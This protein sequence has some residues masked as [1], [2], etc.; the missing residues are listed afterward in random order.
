MVQA[1][2]QVSEGAKRLT[3]GACGRER[4]EEGRKMEV[5]RDRFV[6]VAVSR[7]RGSLL[8]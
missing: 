1:P 5:E 4:K 6:R 7:F 8:P 3:P 2:V